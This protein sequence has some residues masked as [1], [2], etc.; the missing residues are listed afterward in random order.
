[1]SVF[2]C[3]NSLA[4]IPKLEEFRNSIICEETWK[5]AAVDWI[6]WLDSY[7]D[8]TQEQWDFIWA[9]RDILEKELCPENYKTGVHLIAER[10]GFMGEHIYIQDGHITTTMHHSH[11]ECEFDHVVNYGKAYCCKC[12]KDVLITDLED[13]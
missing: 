4:F 2:I 5:K 1:M 10:S 12:N 8:K 13:F 9:V 6:N 7:Y 11:R 3:T